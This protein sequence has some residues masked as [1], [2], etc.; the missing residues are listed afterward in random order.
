ME[1]NEE[2]MC[3]LQHKSSQKIY[4]ASEIISLNKKEIDKRFSFNGCVT[5]GDLVQ[6]ADEYF[7]GKLTEK[8]KDAGFIVYTRASRSNNIIVMIGKG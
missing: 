4:K 6:V 1:D 8:Q 3:E 7:E 5:I 2:R